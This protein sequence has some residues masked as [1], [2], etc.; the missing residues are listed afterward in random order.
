MQLLRQPPGKRQP[1]TRALMFFDNRVLDLS[2]RLKRQS[3]FLR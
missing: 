2:K 1:Q 3:Y